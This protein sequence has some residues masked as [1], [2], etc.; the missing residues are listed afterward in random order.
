MTISSWLTILSNSKDITSAI[1]WI[2]RGLHLIFDFGLATF[3]FLASP[4]HC[5]RQPSRQIICCFWRV[6]VRHS[7]YFFIWNCS[8]LPFQPCLAPYRNYSSKSSPICRLLLSQNSLLFR[9]ILWSWHH[10]HDQR[11]SIP[12]DLAWVPISLS[13]CPKR[14]KPYDILKGGRRSCWLVYR[15]HC[16]AGSVCQVLCPKLWWCHQLQRL[17]YRCRQEWTCNWELMTCAR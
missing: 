13:Y 2:R 8:R 7:H 3:A 1:F 6:A 9:W 12:V 15:E 10:L 17:R 16:S 14:L 5:S 11:L 4:G